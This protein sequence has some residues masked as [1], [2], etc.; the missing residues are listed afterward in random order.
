MAFFSISLIKE[1][2][3]QPKAVKGTLSPRIRD[4]RVVLDDIKLSK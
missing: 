4:G 1:I 3:E 2:H